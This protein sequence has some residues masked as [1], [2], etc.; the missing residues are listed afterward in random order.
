M[1]IFSTPACIVRVSSVTL[2]EAIGEIEPH[3]V[4]LRHDT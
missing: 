4:A 3:G 2:D 1:G